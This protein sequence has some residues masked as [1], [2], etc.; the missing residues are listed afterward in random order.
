MMVGVASVL[1]VIII[2]GAYFAFKSDQRKDK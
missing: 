1:L 2:I